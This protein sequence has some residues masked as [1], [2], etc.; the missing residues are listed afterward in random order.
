M[1][2]PHRAPRQQC[3]LC[4]LPR[5][6]WAMV[7]DFTEPVCRG[8]VNYEG[9]DR[10]EMVLDAARQMKRSHGF[11]ESRP[12]LKSHQPHGNLSS[13]RS[14]SEH[15]PMEP[16]RPLPGQIERYENRNRNIIGD[17]SASPQR[18]ANGI[19]PAGPNGVHG[20]GDDTATDHHRTPTIPVTSR[21]VF[22]MHHPLIHSTAG[23]GILPP[24]RHGFG[25][26]PGSN[27][28]GPVPPNVL[29]NGKHD[30]EE[31]D[32][33]NSHH[34]E[35]NPF[36]FS[37]PEE[38]AKRPPI[39]R[40]TVS[41]LSSSVPFEIRFKKDHNV[42]GRVFAF[43]AVSKNGID[44]ELKVFMEYP[45]GSGNIY[46]SASSVAK[47]MHHDSGKDVGKGLSSGYKYLEYE[48]KHGHGDW[49]ILSELL[50]ETVRFFKEP[51][52][53]DL[54]PAPYVHHN[55]PPLPSPSTC[56]RQTTPG[57]LPRGPVGQNSLDGQGKKRKASPEPDSDFGEHRK[58][59]Q[60]IQ[61]QT[62]AL[63]LTITSAGYG[64]ASS[65]SVSPLSNHTPTPPDGANGPVHTG[66]SPMAALM[67]VT[68]NLASGS[69]SPVRSGNEGSRSSRHNSHSPTS[70]QQQTLRGLR[71]TSG[72]TGEGTS[73]MPES[74][75]PSESLK[76]TI[77]HERLE[78]THFVQCP[79]IGDHKFCFP[80]SRD[81]IKRQGAG[82]EVYCPS[83]KKCPL[84]GSNVPWAFMQGEIATILG[85]DYKD[86]K[87]KKE[88]DT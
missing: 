63:K 11:H 15:G 57:G 44:F 38:M 24:G 32:S 31:G 47:Q 7:H 40:E 3:Y 45:L 61:N 73:T 69:G 22:P 60:W 67:N 20:R 59:Q 36:K 42:F 27:L 18:L 65:T 2:M 80:C 71:T 54:L 70:T 79:S 52:K 9:A 37:S 19:P 26:G 34:N 46:N 51:V 72:V 4:D 83:A 68:D 33:H 81:S 43:D 66:P 74:T 48:M 75:V 87:I 41:M 58:R 77:C 17:Y 62:E 56:F 13:N 30:G 29:H 14:T 82:A 55:I 88:R 23:I 25:S 35:E 12:S 49:K 85:D 53:Q 28:S 8:C 10:I 76:C 86:M 84:V 5:M 78:D 39:V 64:S 16:P 6:P 21:T 50:S 1:S